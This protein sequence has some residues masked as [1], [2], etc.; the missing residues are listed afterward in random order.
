MKIKVINSGSAGNAY[1]LTANSGQRLL[2][3]C[4]V[5]SA[6]LKVAL[7][8]DLSDLYCISTHVHQ[9]HCKSASYLSKCGVPVLTTQGVIDLFGKNDHLI[10]AK[11]GVELLIDKFYIRFFDMVHNVPTLGALIFHPEMGNLV[12]ITDTKEVNYNFK[13]VSHW[14]IE[15]NYC[16][17]YVLKMTANGSSDV[18]RILDVVDRH[19]SVQACESYLRSQDLTKS[20]SICLVHLSDRN[21]HAKEFKQRIERATGVPTYIA[22]PGLELDLNLNLW[23]NES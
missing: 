1:L 5:A 10:A 7:D 8:F 3:D 16:E 20:E 19:F 12:Y 13:D 23:D 15:S 17:E 4:G 21:A 6:K 11:H 14:L 9:D 18:G 2:L 22:E